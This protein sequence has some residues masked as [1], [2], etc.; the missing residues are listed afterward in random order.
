MEEAHILTILALTFGLVMFYAL[1]VNHKMAI[2]GLASPGTGFKSDL[3][4]DATLRACVA[5]LSIGYG[6]VLNHVCF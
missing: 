3:R 5:F 1:Y 2:T 4:I 6:V